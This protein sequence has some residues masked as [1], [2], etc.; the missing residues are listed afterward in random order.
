MPQLSPA[1]G[2]MIFLS[3]TVIFFVL[4]IMIRSVTSPKMMVDKKENASQSFRFIS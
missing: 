2:S 4:V 3:V 1:S